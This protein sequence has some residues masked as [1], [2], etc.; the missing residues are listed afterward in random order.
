MTTNSTMFV[1]LT[2]LTVDTPSSPNATW[3]AMRHLA[4]V[5]ML[6]GE[7][8]PGGT[9][10]FA[11]EQR[12]VG[13]GD[14]EDALL[15][16]ATAAL[17][18]QGVVIGWQ[19]ADAVVGPLL[20]ATREGDP[21]I[22]AAFLA[23][24]LKLITTPSVDLAIAHGGAGAPTFTAVAADHGIDAPTATAA[25]VESAW[26]FGNTSWLRGE[27]EAHAVAAWRLWLAE[28]NGVAADVS[29]QFEQWWKDRQR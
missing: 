9:W 26:S 27:A 13:A 5:A 18:E 16:W 17:P 1:S 20:G 24:L 4:A 11:L 22:A 3:L 2:V 21:E 7:R 25:Q 12:A 10:T 29:S 28:A 15:A 8:A 6:I 14:G 19:L 23:Q